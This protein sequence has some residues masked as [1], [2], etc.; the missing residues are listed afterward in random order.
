RL[1]DKS[2]FRIPAVSMWLRWAGLIVVLVLARVD[3]HSFAMR[4]D[5]G[6]TADGIRKQR[7][8]AKPEEIQAERRFLTTNE[9]GPTLVDERDGI[10]N[11]NDGWADSEQTPHRRVPKQISHKVQAKAERSAAVPVGQASTTLLSRSPL[12]VRR[13][14]PAPRSPP[15]L[16]TAQSRFEEIRLRQR[17][18]EI[19]RAQVIRVPLSQADHIRKPT[20]FTT[21]NLNRSTPHKDV[22]ESTVRQRTVPLPPVEPPRHWARHRARVRLRRPTNKHLTDLR[23]PPRVSTMNRDVIRGEAA[24]SA[25]LISD[26]DV[27]KAVLQ[28][29]I[30]SS[31]TS[32]R[33]NGRIHRPSFH[34]LSTHSSNSGGASK[35]PVSIRK[36]V[37]PSTLV[38]ATTRPTNRHVTP[39]TR[40]PIISTK[41]TPKLTTKSLNNVHREVIQIVDPII[42]KNPSAVAS[43]PFPSTSSPTIPLFSSSRRRVTSLLS[44]TQNQRDFNL[45]RGL[46]K[47]SSTT[48]SHL[49]LV[50]SSLPTPTITFTEATTT[51]VLSSE[52]EASAAAQMN[53]PDFTLSPSTSA[54][55][56]S[57]VTTSDFPLRT[58][59]SD[60]MPAITTKNVESEPQM[61][62][63]VVKETSVRRNLVDHSTSNEDAFDID[64]T[65][66]DRRPT[67]I[68]PSRHPSMSEVIEGSADIAEG[69]STTA[70]T[71]FT[72]ITMSD[73]LTTTTA[74]PNSTFDSTENDSTQE[75]TTNST[76]FPLTSLQDVPLRNVI[77]KEELN[78]N[79]IEDGLT[80]TLTPPPSSPSPMP[81]SSVQEIGAPGAAPPNDSVVEA[82]N[83]AENFME[84]ARRLR[85]L[86]SEFPQQRQRRWAKIDDEVPGIANLP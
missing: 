63:E 67:I 45:N 8:V 41:S 9:D 44:R 48:L 13:Q 11:S 17:P 28:A 82:L 71:T 50:S 47:Q 56:P 15:R 85:I 51:A 74:I 30:E 83:R 12:A 10:A 65:E 76:P 25:D 39:I 35:K 52:N 59:S 49:S 27:E 36:E 73:D 34:R 72:T 20:L 16:Q 84:V 68:P 32:S 14:L 18:F 62:T 79:L 70:F 54:D 69:H 61:A 4:H 21:S 78:E 26:S 3:H 80:P 66:F 58:N 64:P 81:V 86:R 29:I 55:L 42:V 53:T 46:H 75:T 40:P 19:R 37:S 24:T 23:A 6:W 38:T 5:E 43:R 60:E 77:P 22:L 1:L 2:L 31:T 33:K 7:N 57:P